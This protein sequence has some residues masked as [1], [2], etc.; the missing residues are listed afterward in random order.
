MCV[1]VCVC[2]CVFVY[3]CLYV[4]VCV[5]VVRELGL[6]AFHFFAL[7]KFVDF[8]I[9]RHASP[10]STPPTLYG[11]LSQTPKCTAT[12][13][14]TS[15]KGGRVGP[16]PPWSATVVTG[17]T[18]SVSGLQTTADTHTHTHT[19][20][21]TRWLNLSASGITRLTYEIQFIRE[22]DF[23]KILQIKNY[24]FWICQF[25][26]FL[27][28]QRFTHRILLPQCVMFIRAMFCSP[29]DCHF[30]CSSD[31]ASWSPTCCF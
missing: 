24:M 13:C 19:H 8:L 9:H 6:H 7:N 30:G 11:Q 18:L 27:T 29:H 1:C 12:T 26:L 16:R 15:R 17:C 4:Y 2:V 23:P 5:R 21:Y 31:T 25:V 3:V 14:G 22:C 10:S 28:L 20:I